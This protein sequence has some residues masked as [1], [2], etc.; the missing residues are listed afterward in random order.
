M[1]KRILYIETGMGFGGAAISMFELTSNLKNHKPIIAFFSSK[2]NDVTSL[3]NNYNTYFLNTRFS[4]FHKAS[5][6]KKLNRISHNDYF[7]II[8]SKL[9]TL[10]SAIEDYVLFIKICRIIK[11]E[12]ISIVHINNCIHPIPLK[13]ARKFSL[14]TIVHL[15][16]HVD[17][18]GRKKDAC[19]RA[20]HTLIAPTNKIHNFAIDELGVNK[21][22]IKI[23]YNSVNP[24][25]YDLV[26]QGKTVRKQYNVPDD[27][28]LLGMFARI[29]PMKGQLQLA[30]ASHKL[31][32]NN[33]NIMCMFIGDISDGDIS[34]YHE[35]KTYIKNSGF[36]NRFIF[37]GYRDNAP[38]YYNATDIVIHGSIANEAFGRV[39]IESWAAHKPIIATN[40]PASVELIEHNKTGI[41]VESENIEELSDAILRLS[42]DPVER[43]TLAENGYR[44]I[45]KTFSSKIVSTS[46][47]KIYNTLESQG[48]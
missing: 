26:E 22:K 42:G 45:E 36:S 2:E 24:E 14:P 34:Y 12:N 31:L 17:C 29:I 25:L 30:R 38:E 32:K 19:N 44:R 46:I 20:F 27:V 15:R 1:T 11:R 5:F 13:A 10:L 18:A 43:K 33:H 3:F 35:L 16:G 28:I 40:I 47:E 9:F 23:I 41:L 8:A 7:H 37:T 6:N 21:N 4:Y 39:I 48:N